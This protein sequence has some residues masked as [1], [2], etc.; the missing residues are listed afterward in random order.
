MQVGGSEE[1]L[2]YVDGRGSVV[3]D[4]TWDRWETEIE[5]FNKNKIFRFWMEN[6]YRF[7]GFFSV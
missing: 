2:I 4:G 5:N 7:G 3:G 1:R 6:F